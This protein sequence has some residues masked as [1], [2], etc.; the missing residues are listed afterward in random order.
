MTRPCVYFAN[1]A[2]HLDYVMIWTALPRERR[3]AVRPVAGRD[4]WARTPVRRFVSSRMFHALMVDRSGT[5]SS[6][7]AS[8]AAM[9]HALDD[10]DSL[11]VFPE[12]TRST[13][14][15]VHP[16]RSGLYHLARTRPGVDFVPVFVENTHRILPKGR[17]LPVPHR[18]RV[19]FGTP[20]HARAD[21]DK[22]AFL[23]RAR[24]ALIALGADHDGCH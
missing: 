4:Y 16:F 21:E 18:T 3:R 5:T 10:G 13:D 12:G 9:L 17:L 24:A 6:A 14:G 19:V 7:R 23:D 2:S 15:T 8:I 20:V 1:H 22:R 11:V